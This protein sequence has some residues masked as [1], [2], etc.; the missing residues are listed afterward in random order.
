MG[1]SHNRARRRRHCQPAYR[2]NGRTPRPAMTPQRPRRSTEPAVETPKVSEEDIDRQGSG[3]GLEAVP[4]HRGESAGRVRPA[5]RGTL[6]AEL[7]A[8]REAEATLESPTRPR[9]STRESAEVEADGAD[10]RCHRACVRSTCSP[11]AAPGDAAQEAPTAQQAA[12][13]ETVT[14][15]QAVSQDTQ[16]QGGQAALEVPNAMRAANSVERRTT[17][18]DLPQRE[19]LRP[20]GHWSRRTPSPSAGRVHHRHSDGRAR[21]AGRR[22]GRPTCYA[23]A[24]AISSSPA[25]TA[26]CH[27]QLEKSVQPNYP[28]IARRLGKQ[29]VVTVRVLVDENGQGRRCRAD[30]ARLP[31][32]DSTKRR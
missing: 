11:T 32:T 27:R 10:L 1:R 6:Q 22:G 7:E 13:N 17:G 24:L 4:D 3:A 23:P 15:Q 28:L 2:R 31:A 30:S 25:G 19:L 16:A 8:Q 26:S 14:P 9:I 12:G 29:A 5:D 20:V 18:E 21:N